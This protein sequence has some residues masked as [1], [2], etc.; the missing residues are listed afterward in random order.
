MTLISAI[1]QA[2]PMYEN[3]L[4]FDCDGI[5]IDRDELPRQVIDDELLQ[6]VIVVEEIC[7]CSCCCLISSRKIC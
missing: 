5:E 1:L 7:R 3:N 6:S 4:Q 2:D